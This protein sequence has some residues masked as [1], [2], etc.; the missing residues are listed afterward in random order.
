M[1]SLGIKNTGFQFQPNVNALIDVLPHIPTLKTLDLQGQLKLN[2]TQFISIL[3]H[4]RIEKL[5]IVNVMLNRPDA[6]ELAQ[7]IPNTKLNELDVR[8]NTLSW[9]EI[10]ALHDAIKYKSGTKILFSAPLNR[11][12]LPM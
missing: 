7:K 9:N 2:K 12:F 1:E 8:Y 11:V 6:A 10:N 4:T 3:D 5:Y